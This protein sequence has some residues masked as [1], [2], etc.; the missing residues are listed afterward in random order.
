MHAHMHN[1]RVCI[2]N[3]NDC[4][5]HR[6]RAFPAACMEEACTLGC[7]AARPGSFAFLPHVCSCACACRR[8]TNLLNSPPP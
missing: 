5:R 8:A 2:A 6:A 1:A 7:W 4:G 3:A